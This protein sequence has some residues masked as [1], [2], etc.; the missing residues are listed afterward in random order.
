MVENFAYIPSTNG[1]TTLTS[2]QPMVGLLL[3]LI[4]Q[5]MVENFASSCFHARFPRRKSELIK[6]ITPES[7]FELTK[8]ALSSLLTE[9]NINYIASREAEALSIH[10]AVKR[11]C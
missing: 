3:H 7:R 9:S 5:S 6:I 8:S 11:A 10:P 4:S 2:R 1:W